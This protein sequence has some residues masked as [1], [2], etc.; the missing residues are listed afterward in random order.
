MDHGDRTTAGFIGF[1]YSVFKV[2]KGCAAIRAAEKPAGCAYIQI[3]RGNKRLW[4]HLNS[5]SR[6]IENQHWPVNRMN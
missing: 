5:I 3:R 6:E 4:R 1:L 2:M